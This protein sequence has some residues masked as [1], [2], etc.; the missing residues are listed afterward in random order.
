MSTIPTL[1]PAIGINVNSKSKTTLNSGGGAGFGILGMKSN[2]GHVSPFKAD[3]QMLTSEISRMGKEE[4]RQN[5]SCLVSNL[6]QIQKK[7]VRAQPIAVSVNKK[8]KRKDSVPTAEKLARSAQSHAPTFIA[9]ENNSTMGQDATTAAQT[10]NFSINKGSTKSN[11]P[12]YFY[13]PKENVFE[14]KRGS[15]YNKGQPKAFHLTQPDNNL[16][17]CIFLNQEGKNKRPSDS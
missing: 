11:F 17:K 14:S 16:A 1:N 12:N 2:R 5:F 9:T 10:A 6:P 3:K 7:R 13:A 15:R 4:T 8:I